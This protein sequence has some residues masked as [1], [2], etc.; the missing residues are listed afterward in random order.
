MQSAALFGSGFHS[1]PQEVATSSSPAASSRSA[2]IS[3]RVANQSRT[4]RDDDSSTS[5][6][7][8]CPTADGGVDLLVAEGD[9]EADSL[10]GVSSLAGSRGDQPNGSCPQRDSALR[11]F[12]RAL[13]DRGLGQCGELGADFQ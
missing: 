11:L 1:R 8:H 4:S 10:D 9:L 7:R 5:P 13:S 3:A 12:S 2:G 6:R